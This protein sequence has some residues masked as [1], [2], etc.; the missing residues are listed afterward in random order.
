[1]PR[2]KS[3]LWVDD[4]ID[5]LESQVTFLRQQGFDVETA[6]HG[7]DALQLLRGQAYGVVLPDEQLPGRRGL[8]CP[9]GWQLVS[10]F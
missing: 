3:V 4:E 1:M 10:S 9:G 8:E 2:P 5:F 7:D 6:V